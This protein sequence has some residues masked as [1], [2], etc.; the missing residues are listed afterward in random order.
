MNNFD[1]T[2]FIDSNNEYRIKLMSD[3]ERERYASIIFNSKTTDSS[4]AAYTLESGYF[5]TNKHTACAVCLQTNKCPGHYGLI[6]L[7]YPIVTNTIIAERFFKLIQ[8]LCPCCSNFPIENAKDAL[9]LKPEDRFNFIKS[10]VQKKQKNNINVCPYCHN[11]FIFITVENSLPNYKFYFNQKVANKSVQLNPIY[12]YSILQNMSNQTCE[13]AGFNITTNDPR[14]YMSKY[15][16][17]IPNKL[18]IATLDSHSSS[19]TA[20]YKNIIDFMVAELNKLYQTSIKSNIEIPTNEYGQLFNKWYSALVAKYTLILDMTRE[21][22]INACLEALSKSD[23][24]HIEPSVSLIGRLKGKESSYFEKGIIATRHLVS[25]RTVLGADTSIH[26]YEIG[27]PQK[28]CNKM[29]MWIPVYAENLELLKQF[30]AS[31]SNIKINDY[32]KIRANKVHVAQTDMRYTIEPRTAIESASKLQPGDKIFMS[33]LPGSVVQHCRFPSVREESWAS[34]ILVPT[35]HTCMTIPLAACEYKNA[36]FDGDETEL[37]ATHSHVTDIECILLNSIFRQ[38]INHK[39]ADVGVLFQAYDSK[40]EIPKL[41]ADTEIG[42]RDIRNSS[43]SVIARERF[44]PAKTV[45]DFINEYL[46]YITGISKDS[47]Y[48]KIKPI[49][50]C[51]KKLKIINNKLDKERCSLNN[52]DFFKYLILTIGPD[53]SLTLIDNIIQ[54]GYNFGYYKPI[55]LGNEIR[56]YKNDIRKKIEEIKDKEYEDL[57]R[58]ERSNKSQYQK[59]LEKYIIYEEAKRPIQDLL[60]ENIKGTNVA[61]TGM[62]KNMS[63]YRTMLVNMEAAIIN[64]DSLPHPSL[65]NCTRTCASYPQHSIDPMAYGFARHGYISNETIPSE[66]FFDCT[67]QRHALYIKGNGVAAQGY[68]QK[69]FLMAFG[70]NIVDCNGGV[71]F[72]N[73][74]VCPCYGSSS[75]N[76]RYKFNQPLNDISM[77]E[78]EF[79]KKYDIDNK[80]IDINKSEINDKDNKNN[81]ELYKLYKL[82]NEISLDYDKQTSFIERKNYGDSF[83]AG[84]DFEQLFNPETSGI[85]P[86]KT[87]EKDISLFI[88]QLKKTFAPPGMK[89]RYIL[90]NLAQTEYYFR[91][92][93]ATFKIP[94]KLL[95][96]AYYYFINS[97]VDAGEPVGMKASL[98]VGEALTQES[99]D[100]IHHAAEGSIEHEHLVRTKGG[101]RF[102]ELVGGSVHK[103][104]VITL[105]FY[106]S[107]EEAVKKFAIREETIYFRDI[108]TKLEIN[109]RVGISNDVKKLHPKIANLFDK[110]DVAKSYV[111]MVWN[112]SK[113]ADYNISLSEVYETLYKNY[114]NIAFMTGKPVNGKEFLVYI[115]F[116]PSTNTEKLNN[117]VQQFQSYGRESI[118]HGDCVKNC[119]VTQNASTGEWIVRCNEI[120]P[121]IRAYEKILYREEVDP[122]KCYTTDTSLMMNMYGVFETGARLCEEL[123]YTA[124]VLSCVGDVPPR[125]MK[126]IGLGCV[127]G[128]EFFTA[129]SHSAF[130]SNIDYLRGCNFEQPT[131]F[132]RKAI[133]EGKFRKVEDTVAAAFYGMLPK[134]GTGYSKVIIFRK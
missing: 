26:S 9:S 67:M 16:T 52:Q 88:N 56:F 3:S 19:V 61:Y 106:D 120:N 57:K 14:N 64:N 10:E 82:I 93:A 114:E 109:I 29:G 125:H 70:Q 59:D 25:A 84:Y 126:T 111:K 90:L 98:S 87:D 78:D 91:Q 101:A 130:G 74:F 118:I 121:R 133:S 95:L 55:T 124:T 17:I 81:I 45:A 36:D 22:T 11:E 53:R 41:K 80:D 37:Y 46:D 47:P 112:L 54:L 128:G 85:T 35:N 92:K 66:T 31:M 51:D 122:A 27:F 42:V 108:W 72:E 12:V 43:D 38:L 4:N 30:V 131:Q 94:S 110:L 49:N 127:S 34:H 15:I 7:P 105:G 63:C 115:Y 104:C 102:E 79:V 73:K 62:L 1:L 8:L 58:I 5:G 44:Y 123:L 48:S 33:L 97:L 117:I 129:V 65:N 119:F 113:I 107:S 100:A 23:K 40:V 18:R 71:V 39:H 134:I 83:V 69:R 32:S 96:E 28:Y 6:S 89:Q 116:T 86:G 24:K 2:Y 77:P 99:L 20:S 76:P 68:L 103:N 75:I 60:E 50:Y 13:Y 21:S 132:I